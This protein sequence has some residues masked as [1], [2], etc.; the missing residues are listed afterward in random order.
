LPGEEILAP[1]DS[2]PDEP[3][4]ADIVRQL[5]ADHQGII[6]GVGLVT[7]VWGTAEQTLC[8]LFHVLS[9]LGERGLETAGVIF[10]APSNTETRVALVNNL[11]EYRCR[12][13]RLGDFDDRLRAYWKNLK[14]KIDTLKNGRNAIVHGVILNSSHG[15]K[16]QR[17]R[18]SPALSDTL[19]IQ[20]RINVEQVLKGGQHIGFGPDEL[21]SHEQAVW[22]VIERIQLLIAA[23]RPRMR[24]AFGPHEGRDPEELLEAVSRL[25]GEANKIQD[26]QDQQGQS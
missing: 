20:S 8:E 6:S 17:L 14:G 13:Q 19:R 12:M 1:M 16:N 26:E 21:K 3:Q 2:Q 15:G 9:Q 10:Y 23:F 25:D 22:R 11:V 4:H 24:L 18:L 5:E 7:R